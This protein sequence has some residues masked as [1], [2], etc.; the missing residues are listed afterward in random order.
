MKEVLGKYWKYLI[1][2]EVRHID[3]I[4]YNP[5]KH[6]HV[7]EP[8]NWLFSGIHV[9]IVP[10]NWSGIPFFRRIFYL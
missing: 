9:G 10:P 4:H 3:Y 2:D 7:L 5:V 8:T 6:S 1:R